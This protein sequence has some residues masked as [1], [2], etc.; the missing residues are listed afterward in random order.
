MDF[1]DALVRYETSLWNAVDGHLAAA[2][3]PRLASLSALRVIARHAP[4]ARVQEVREDLLITVGAASKLVDR[5]E[6]DGYVERRPHPTDRRSSLLALTRAGKQAHS[7]GVEV[8]RRALADYLADEDVRV[9]TSALQR[10]SG[11]LE[12]VSR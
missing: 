3:A 8:M 10:L 2:G 9:L 5:L 7:E 6:R 4:S 12:S 1:F 11:A